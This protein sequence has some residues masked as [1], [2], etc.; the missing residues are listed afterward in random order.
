MI[1]NIANYKNYFFDTVKK[2][3]ATPSPTGYYEQIEPLMRAYAKEAGA[4][5]EVNN[6]GSMIFTISG[7]SHDRAI[8]LSAHCD[9]LGLMVRS[10]SANGDIRFTCL[11]GVCLNN[12]DGEYCFIHTR[13][14]KDYRATVLTLSP[15]VHVFP[16]A[17]DRLRNEENM[18]I[19]LDEKVHCADDVLALG[20]RAGDYVFFDTRTEVVNDFL[21]SRF[22]DDKGSV[23]VLLTV[24]KIMKDSGYVPE[25]D[26]KFM[27]DM[28]EEVG[29]GGAVVPE[30]IFALL[31]LDM[32]CVGLDLQG[33][34]YKVSICAKDSGGPY[35]YGF[36]TFLIDR[37]KELK[38]DY[39][40]D[41]FPKYGSDV[42]A[43][44]RGGNNVRG[45]LIGSGVQASHGL[46]RTH[47]DGI[48]NTIK[49]SLAY[50][51][52]ASELII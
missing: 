28:F 7:K 10:I 34:E 31:A 43:M 35:D 49:L 3:L 29:H 20:I 1:Q 16:D 13:E 5:Y 23:A 18:Y 40:V 36:T 48:A 8:G 45:A 26:V 46:E 50:I 33:N 30:G 41:I 19:R 2:I 39:A 4:K 11:G 17:R 15:S 9:T 14:G 12:L 22:I 25:Y 52:R 32:G 27:F 21:K 44:W 6:K 38:L 42:G 51:E 47:F 37:A 24:A